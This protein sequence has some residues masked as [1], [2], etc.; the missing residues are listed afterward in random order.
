MGMFDTIYY[1]CIT[2][3]KQAFSQTKLS[4]CLMDTIKVGEIFLGDGITINLIMKDE[5]ENCKSENCIEIVKGKIINVIPVKKATHRE[6]S[7]GSLKNV[8]SI[9]QNTTEDKDVS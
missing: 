6:G 9:A 5:C 7:W 3:G 8:T 4:A 2:C 1:K